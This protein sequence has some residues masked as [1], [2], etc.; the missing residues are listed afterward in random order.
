M[1]YREEIEGGGLS[2]SCECSRT[3]TT[4]NRLLRGVAALLCGRP[5]AAPQPSAPAIVDLYKWRA[6]T[7]D[8]GR[9]RALHYSPANVRTGWRCQNL[10]AVDTSESG[11]SRNQCRKHILCTGFEVRQKSE[12]Q[13]RPGSESAGTSLRFLPKVLPTLHGY[14]SEPPPLLAL[15]ISALLGL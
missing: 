15:G 10:G 9:M 4:V 14:W 13:P 12:Y 6:Q 5:P 3:V 8:A 1:T 2:S 7:I 11:C